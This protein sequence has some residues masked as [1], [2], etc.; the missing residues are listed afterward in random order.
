[1][2][3]NELHYIA[4]NFTIDDLVNRIKSVMCYNAMKFFLYGR[5]KFS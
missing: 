4:S 1:M 2:N 3:K 5:I